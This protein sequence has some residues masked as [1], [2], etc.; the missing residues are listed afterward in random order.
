MSNERI[1]LTR[2]ARRLSVKRSTQESTTG[3]V[4]DRNNYLV[5]LTSRM[6]SPG[7]GTTTRIVLPGPVGILVLEALGRD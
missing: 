6:G 7:T 2:F 3:S 5:H 4:V 1:N